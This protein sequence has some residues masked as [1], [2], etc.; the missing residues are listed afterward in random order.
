MGTRKKWE[1]SVTLNLKKVTKSN[2]G[3]YPKISDN[4]R[5]YVLALTLVLELEKSPTR[6]NGWSFFSSATKS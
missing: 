1:K 3:S 2:T 6:R 4:C 5:C